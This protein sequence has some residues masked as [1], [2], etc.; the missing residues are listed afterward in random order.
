MNRQDLNSITEELNK[1]KASI[2][3]ISQ[4]IESEIEDDNNKI[5]GFYLVPRKSAFSNIP[6]SNIPVKY[7]VVGAKIGHKHP[8]IIGVST[9]IFV[10]IVCDMTEGQF[11]EE[12]LHFPSFYDSRELREFI[13][14]KESK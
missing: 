2:N 13:Q 9:E 3:T 8:R 4:L 10:D 14:S 7:A 11:E 1:I 12:H 5:V 6:V